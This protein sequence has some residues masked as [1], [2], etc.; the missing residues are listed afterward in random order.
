M[1]RY[2]WLGLAIFLALSVAGFEALLVPSPRQPS[3]ISRDNFDRIEVG[4]TVEEVSLILGGPPGRYTDRRYHVFYHGI[5][6][7]HWWIGEDAV[8]IIEVA[9]DENDPTAPDRVYGK[10]FEPHPAE[11]VLEQ[12]RNLL[13]W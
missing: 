5:S 10:K 11:S 4:M 6:F 1:R 8:I 13:P 12:C 2:R 9:R 7:R 3:A